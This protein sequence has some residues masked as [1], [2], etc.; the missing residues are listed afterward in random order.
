MDRK[1]ILVLVGSVVLLFVW[2]QIV[3]ILFPPIPKP[4]ATNVIA[5]VTNAVHLPQTSIEAPTNLI[6]PALPMTNALPPLTRASTPERLEAIETSEAI[7][8]FTSHGGGLK[9][10]ELKHYKENVGKGSRLAGPTNPLVTLNARAEVP[11]L[12]LRGDSALTGDGTFAMARIST[13]QIRCE[14]TMSNGLAV[15][16]EFTVL[17]N[18]LLAARIRIE[19]RSAQALAISQH[20]VAAGTASSVDHNED[21]TLLG[22]YWY[23]GASHESVGPSYF[24]NR[25]IGGCLGLSSSQPRELYLNG[26]S[27]VLWVA[28]H[29][30]F[31]T[32][33]L[34]AGSNQPA[35]ALMVHRIHLPAMPAIHGKAPS[36]YGYDASLIYPPTILP[37]GQALARDFKLYSG[38]K[39]YKTL[40]RIGHQ[41]DV[42]MGYTGFF[43]WFAK[44]LLLSMNGLYLLVP[45]YA[46]VI[47]LITI[48]IK[49]LFWPLT[50]ASTRSMKRMSALQPQMK[51]IQEKYRD[52]PAK[53]NRKLMEFMKENKVS[54]MGGCLPMLLQI[55]VFIGFYQMIRTAIEL[56]GVRFLWAADLSQPDTIAY[57]PG[58]D[59]PI[60]PLPLI[61]GATMFWQAR[62]TPPTPGVDPMQQR[63]MKYMPM[64][65]MVFLYNFSAGLTLY[66]TV[67]NLLTIAQMK[68]T[69]TAEPTSPPP[70]PQPLPA[71]KKL[72]RSRN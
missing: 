44:A 4:A 63:I 52:D 67:Q 40:S 3:P 32:T 57:V 35:A 14:K 1:S 13:N 64:I 5:T 23:D 66:W 50:Q 34:I 70:T 71:R 45:H 30:Q 24:D 62:M 18:Y 8:T 39:E 6:A 59:F 21:P 11:I 49:L 42:V 9:K 28:A 26:H 69:R 48:I 43:G 68:L 2:F 15:I 16:K 22:A 10:V 65:F 60:N 25:G 38:P 72:P 27:N 53:M 20:S 12:A 61:M 29:N 37:A 51:A 17:S 36:P 31:F 33:A 41:V 46:V 19:N 54:P 56:R 47:I 58:L 7:Y 55:P